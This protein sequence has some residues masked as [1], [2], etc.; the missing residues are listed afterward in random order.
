[1]TGERTHTDSPGATPPTG[2]EIYDT[3]LGLSVEV[4]G[5]EERASTGDPDAVRRLETEGPQY[6][7]AMRVLKDQAAGL[8]VAPNLSE[9]DSEKT[10]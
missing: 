1:M 8:I 2:G 9:Q 7:E 4:E 3:W 6:R 10:N 5:L